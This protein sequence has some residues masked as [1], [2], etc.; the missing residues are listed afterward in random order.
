MVS[1]NDMLRAIIVDDDPK[2]VK[3]LKLIIKSIDLDCVGEGAN[4]N[5]A[6]Q[7]YRTLRPDVAFLDINMPVK[8]GIKALKEIIAEF[9]DANVIMITSH[10]DKQM[11]DE[12]II[13]GAK[14]YIRK[15]AST[16]D[17]KD[18]VTSAIK[19]LKP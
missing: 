12:C 14:D 16:Y 8:G 15:D 1:E 7:L 13:A 2:C 10:A 11:V 17:I 5:E 18:R 3:F 9:P 4:G 19:E 6:V